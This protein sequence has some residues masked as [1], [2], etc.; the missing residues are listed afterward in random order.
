MPKSVEATRTVYEMSHSYRSSLRDPT[1]FIVTDVEVD[2]PDPGVHSMLSLASVAVDHDGCE[3]GE[4]VANLKPLEDARQ[5][6]GT[7]AW[8]ES[9]PAAWQEATS[10]PQD[11]ARAIRAWTKWIADRPG[12]A[13]FVA[14]PISFDGAWVDWYLK[15]FVGA[16]LFD[17]PREPGVCGGA[18]LDIPSLVM[19]SMGWDYQRC[20]RENYPAVW[21]GGH[22]HSH[23]AI[24]DAKGYAHLFSLL[25]TKRL[26]ERLD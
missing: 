6:S 2:G 15:R 17:R 8:W 20:C 26:P 23:R 4:F 16:R 7:M 1:S 12:K 13:V 21:L 24:D 25:L 5:D 22:S 9:Q 3:L 19:S 11:P 18:G 14:H 10:S